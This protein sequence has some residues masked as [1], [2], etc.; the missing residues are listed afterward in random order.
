MSATNATAAA[1]LALYFENADHTGVGDAGGLLGSVAP[2]NFY[3]SLHTADPTETGDQTTNEANYTSYARVA[4]ARSTSG[5]TSASA[6]PA[7]VKND[8]AIAFPV[9]TGG[10][11]TCTH[12]GIGTSSSGAGTLLFS[13]ALNASLA[14]TNGITPEFAIDALTITLD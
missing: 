4:V 13:G 8:A 5:F 3:I 12:F 11:S 10:S 6:D 14:V 2:G 9:A 1:I 7:T